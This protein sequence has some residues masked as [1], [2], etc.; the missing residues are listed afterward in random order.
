[1]LQLE[2]VC[3]GYGPIEV[4][5]E[6]SLS[7]AKGEIVSVIGVN[8]A[9][10][11]TLLRT[12]SALVPCR[13]G[14]IT[15]EGKDITHYPPHK[16]VEIGLIQVPEG[17]QVFAPLTTY[18]N[19]LLGCYTKY[20][21]L[22]GKGRERLLKFVFDLFPVLAHRRNQTA[23]TLSGGEQQMLA[24]GRAL[25]AEPRL[26]L[27]DEP[28]LGLAPV[29]VETIDQVLRQLNREGLT[30]LL[31]EQNALMALGTANRAYVV[32]VG[33]VALEGEAKKLLDDDKVREV[34][35]GGAYVR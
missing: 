13:K 7:V 19:L 22:G 3:A 35:L 33:R 30:I 27:L 23:G 29:V 32:D 25:M 9:G 31:V 34:Y 26:L 15:F 11:S 20:R 4:I 10:K 16:V 21:K 2:K 8:G 14:R 6:I 12:I 5:H 24:I 17:R 28:S 18:E 1:M